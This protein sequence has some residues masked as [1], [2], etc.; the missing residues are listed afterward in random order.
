MMLSMPLQRTLSLNGWEIELSTFRPPHS[1]VTPIVFSLLCQLF[2]P[3]TMI[4]VYLGM[5]KETAGV[6][7]LPLG[8]LVVPTIA[9]LLI[10]I[11]LKMVTVTYDSNATVA[12]LRSFAQRSQAVPEYLSLASPTSISSP[13]RY[14]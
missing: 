7:E 2:V 14:Q 12:R 6:L 10:S 13:V 9:S 8:L 5:E 1:G 11:L 3:R 4:T